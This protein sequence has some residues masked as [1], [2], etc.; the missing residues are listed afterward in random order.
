MH[1]R[2]K[3]PNG[4]MVQ[5]QTLSLSLLSSLLLY[6]RMSNSFTAVFNMHKILS[7]HFLLRCTLDN[8]N[9]NVQKILFVV[10]G[11]ESFPFSSFT[12]IINTSK[13]FDANTHT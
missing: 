11:V 2:R 10:D 1:S 5:L 9:N 8:N 13:S 4:Q 7:L 6:S 12:L 3:C